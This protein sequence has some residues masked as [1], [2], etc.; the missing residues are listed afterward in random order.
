MCDCLQPHGL[1][2][3][4]FFCPSLSPRV[5]S[6]SCPSSQ[7]CYLSISS[8]VV[9]LLCNLSLL[10]LSPTLGVSPDCSKTTRAIPGPFPMEILSE[11]HW[12]RPKPILTW[13]QSS[14][15]ESEVS[16]L[17]RRNWLE[18]SLELFSRICIHF[19][20]NVYRGLCTAVYS[21]VIIFASKRNCDTEKLSSLFQ[22]N[23]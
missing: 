1:W 19:F 18:L 6:N 14:G 13:L 20:I 3:T 8:F 4:R 12:F 22:F 23:P 2:H 21:F 11:I 5:C 15:F 9:Q 17:W 16:I 7:W 10:I